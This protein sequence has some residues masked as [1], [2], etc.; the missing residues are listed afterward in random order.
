MF[1]EKVIDVQCIMDLFKLGIEFGVESGLYQH[2]I[3]HFREFHIRIQVEVNVFRRVD[4]K[5]KIDSLPFKMIRQALSAL[6]F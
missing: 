6:N 4:P 2:V 1:S 3:Y 5:Q